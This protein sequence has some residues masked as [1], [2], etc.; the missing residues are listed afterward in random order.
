[1][2]NPASFL[3]GALHPEGYHGK[4]K[5]AGFFEGWYVKL[6]SA[7]LSQRWAVIPGI[8]KGISKADSNEREAD[9]EAFVQVLDGSTGR[10]W[11]YPFPESEFEAAEDKFEVRVGKNFF[12]ENEIKLDL[13]QLSGSLQITT[14]FKPWPVTITSPGIMGW[15]GFVPFME[16][17]HGIVSFGHELTGNLL[18]EGK[19]KSFE[20]AKGYIET[21]WGKS[22][23]AGYIWMQTNHFDFNNETSLIASA[24]IIPWL[25]RSFR[26]FIIGLHHE[27]KLYRWTTYN[28]SKEVK[29]ALN[30]K[31]VMWEIVGP[32]GTIEIRA[33]RVRGGLLHAPLV[34]DMH[35]RVEETMDSSIRLTFRDIRNKVICEGAGQAAALEVF[36][37][38]DKLLSYGKG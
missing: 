24:A 21:D 14:P 28:S 7:D 29:L 27:G 30:D 1:M 23:P 32:D 3:K 33:K 2:I 34:K 10:S 38:L 26:G 16:C 35:R 22:F 5:S 17:F 11:F 8:F 25:G 19:E 37:D 9:H 15:Y 12:S 20:K 6:V 4:N 36:G 13:P 18:V 31:E